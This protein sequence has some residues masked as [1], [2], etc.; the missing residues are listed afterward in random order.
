M[1]ANQTKSASSQ[2]VEANT[3][4]GVNQTGNAPLLAM[5]A[6]TREIS[7]RKKAVE[8][9]LNALQK[10]YNDIEEELIKRRRSIR[11]GRYTPHVMACLLILF[12]LLFLL[13]RVLWGGFYAATTHGVVLAALIA[14]AALGTLCVLLMI[15]RRRFIRVGLTLLRWGFAA[16]TL[17]VALALRRGAGDNDY[18][19]VIILLGLSMLFCEIVWIRRYVKKQAS[20]GS[21]RVLAFAVVIFLLAA[22]LLP[23]LPIRDRSGE[24][25]LQGGVLERTVRYD[26][27]ADGYASLTRVMLTLDDTI[28]VDKGEL[29]VLGEVALGESARAVTTVAA[30]AFTGVRSYS[31][32][33]LPESVVRIDANAFRESNVARLYVSSAALHLADGLANSHISEIYLEKAELV[34]LDGAV[35]REGITLRVPAQLLELYQVSYPALA[36]RIL[37]I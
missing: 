37:A 33:R 13:P 22:T 20:S 7:D 8:L 1:R 21:H 29:A 14:V 9:E 23:F 32:V 12:S 5:Q 19:A 26:M 27:G 34:R 15:I 6:V 31:A 36:E 18:L 30:D 24:S 28:N 4:R 25:F 16:A 10:K 17:V 3:K 35:L 2:F 11:M